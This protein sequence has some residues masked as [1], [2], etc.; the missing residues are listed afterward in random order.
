MTTDA[1]FRASNTPLD[2]SRT[3]ADT[4]LETVS[5]ADNALQ[6]SAANSLLASPNTLM[7]NDLL[8]DKDTPWQVHNCKIIDKSVT[9]EQLLPFI[10]HY[11][12]LSDELKQLH[13]L[14]GNLL[15]QFQ[16]PMSAQQAAQLL[17]LEAALVP[18][19]W[20][21]KVT[22]TLVMFCERLQ[23]ALRLKFTNTAK[24]Y[25]PVY[26]TTAEK[27]V[28]ASMQD[29]HFYGDI[30]VLNKGNKPLVMTLDHDRIEIPQL[31][32]YQLLPGEYGLA[33]LALLEESK[34]H[35]T[36]LED[37]INQRLI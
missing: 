30:F 14:T 6:A 21:V 35:I 34:S 20:M 18:T 10:Y 32:D 25:D 37:A 29:W 31:A 19:P 11:D 13:P 22:G 26:T 24:D 7:L 4:S 3:P 5:T 2:P 36:N 28:E 15:K 8:N 23:I 33:A 9:Q 27:A 17:G 12:A 1:S 16:T